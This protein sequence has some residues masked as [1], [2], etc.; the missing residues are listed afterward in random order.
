M[1]NK[2]NIHNIFYSIYIGLFIGALIQLF[3]GQ[4]SSGPFIISVVMVLISGLIGLVIGSI[5]EFLT[6]LLPVSMAS[7]H[8]YYV[9]NNTIAVVVTL[10]VLTSLHGLLNLS[11]STKEDVYMLVSICFIVSLCNLLIYIKHKKLNKQLS[12]YRNSMK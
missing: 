10:C 11:L 5:T 3:K 7:I 1:F 9:V 6:S 4:N 12:Q 2:V 8:R